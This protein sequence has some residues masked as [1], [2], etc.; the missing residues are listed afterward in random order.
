MK[1]LARFA[2]AFFLLPV[3]LRAGELPAGAIAGP[4]ASG[5]FVAPPLAR[6]AS[7]VLLLWG[8]FTPV[9]AASYEVLC[10][11][12]VLVSTP[13]LSYTATHLAAGR[14]Y[15]F[16]VR[17]LDARQQPLGETGKLAAATRAAGAV[18]NVRERGAQGDGRA[19]DT[20][21]IQQAI[22]ACPAGG[23]VLV[24]AGLY[25]VDHLEL[26]SGLTLD[27]EPGATLHFLGRG[28]GHYDP[29][30]VVL[31]G[32]DGPV[33]VSVG[34][35]ITG[36]HADHVTITGGGTIQAN[37]ET[38]WPHAS[39]YRPKVFEVAGARDLFVQGIT[40][41]DPPSWDVHPLDVDGVVF[42]N[43]TF[44][45]RALAH[46]VNADGLDL[47]SCRDVLV[48]GC[49]FGNQDD[50][51]AIKCGKLTPE[52]ARRQRPSADIVVRDCLF[53]GRLGPGSH[54]LGIA[55]G[56]EICGGVQRVLVQDCA[57]RDVASIMNVKANRDRRHARVEDVL[58]QDCS[59]ANTVFG[60]EPWNHG[61]ITVDLFYY[62]RTEDPDAPH[63]PSPDT[64]C[65]R[66][67]HFRNITIDNPRG[68]A[69]YLTGLAEQPIE[70]VSFDHITA[71]SQLGLFARNVDGLT[72]DHVDLTPRSGPAFVWGPNVTHL[73]VQP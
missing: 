21:A 49:A 71:T 25:A 65:F 34:A 5:R 27:L 8:R 36:V 52:Q 30:D 48:V 1:T 31:P 42:A 64:P 47:D 2:L 66:R 46:S 38:W 62:G 53:D 50:S 28:V 9:P 15:H 4:A 24:P 33:S 56:S 68:Y 67:L 35:L 7:T 73:H 14:T 40:V 18:L 17:A 44:N 41:E 23:T 70:D 32:P 16:A 51:I 60:D 58:V 63:P 72:L 6:T 57:F 10:D 69:I 26:K 43:V 12:E 39:D 22:D 19:E 45:R 55:I 20:A 59:Y 29:H 3:W 61:P 54:P 13:A 37:G 11:G